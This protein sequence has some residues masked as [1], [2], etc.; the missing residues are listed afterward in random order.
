MKEGDRIN[1]PV[2]PDQE[3]AGLM[4]NT[5]VPGG[6]VCFSNSTEL[7]AKKLIMYWSEKTADRYSVM[8]VDLFSPISG[9][10]DGIDVCL[11]NANYPVTEPMLHGRRALPDRYGCVEI[12]GFP[13]PK[14]HETEIWRAFTVLSR[15]FRQLGRVRNQRQIS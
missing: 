8:F 2:G 4:I 7:R 9:G 1:L 11:M 5:G 15:V 13:N 14:C 12:E 3:V 10:V 6:V